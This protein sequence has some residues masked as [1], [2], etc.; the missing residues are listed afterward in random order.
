[1]IEG[2]L[3]DLLS[4]LDG[5]KVPRGAATRGLERELRLPLVVPVFVFESVGVPPEHF[6]DLALGGLGTVAVGNRF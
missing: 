4:L 6:L 3:A 5:K 2:R 1:M